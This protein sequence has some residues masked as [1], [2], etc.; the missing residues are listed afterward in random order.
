MLARARKV[1]KRKR[2]K[3]RW[4]LAT[5]FLGHIDDEMPSANTSICQ[6]W[7]WDN[8]DHHGPI[9]NIHYHPLTQF[10]KSPKTFAIE[11]LNVWDCSG[12]A[13]ICYVLEVY[14][15][16]CINCSL[17]IS[18]CIVFF[19]SHIHIILYIHSSYVA[20][21][22]PTCP[23]VTRKCRLNPWSIQVNSLNASLWLKYDQ[24]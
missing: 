14:H 18:R 15:T 11:T 5:F 20:L 19:P 1:I 21:A 8:L 2:T 17:S 10:E 9:Q 12:Q 6:L 3:G 4:L 13:N 23:N 24:V 22:I 16:A 7:S